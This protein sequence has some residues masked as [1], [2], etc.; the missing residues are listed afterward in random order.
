MRHWLFAAV[1]AFA[2]LAAPLA[3]AEEKSK[4]ESECPGFPDQIVCGAEQ[5]V[6]TG[7]CLIAY[8]SI[9]GIPLTDTVC[10]ENMQM[11]NNPF[12]SKE[13]PKE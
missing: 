9:I 6:T 5:V 13:K 10:P 7:I 11:E 1:G 12:R 4:G 8:V 3:L 2:L